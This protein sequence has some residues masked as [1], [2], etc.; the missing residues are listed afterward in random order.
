MSLDYFIATYGY[1]AILAGTF[2]EGETF[3]LIGGFA[4]YEGLLDLPWVIL[5]AF[6]GTFCGD[7]ACFFVGKKY[8]REIINRYPSWQ[9]RADQARSHLAKYQTWLILMLRFMYALRTITL[10]VIG[11]SGMAVR[12]FLLLEVIGGLVWAVSM[13]V[14][15]YLF[16][17]TLAAILGDIKEYEV[18]ILLGIV[19]A[20]ILFWLIH[21]YW[22]RKR[23]ADSL[24]S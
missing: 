1:W 15:G 13:G 2:V 14:G 11:M 21:F 22:P 24:S 10:F 5:V 12:K 23:K 16:G 8:G 3:L 20:G 19:L 17:R 9:T 6:A 7:L 18:K 4:A